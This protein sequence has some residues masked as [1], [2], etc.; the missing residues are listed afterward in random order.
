[1]KRLISAFFALSVLVGCDDTGTGQGASATQGNQYFLNYRYVDAS[2]ADGN[3]AFDSLLAGQEEQAR[4]LFVRSTT[5][6]A[7]GA[8]RH[9]IAAR[10]QADNIATLGAVVGAGIGIAAIRSADVTTVRGQQ[11]LQSQLDTLGQIT[12][13]IGNGAQDYAASRI[14]AQARDVQLNQ[15]RSVVISDHR[16]ARSIVRVRNNTTG[17]YCTGFFIRPHVIATASHCFD[18]GHSMS[19]ER[20]QPERGGDF[21]RGRTVQVPIYQNLVNLKFENCP[22]ARD[23]NDR[24]R[25]CGAEDFAMFV[26]PQRS[27]YFIPIGSP[28]VVGESLTTIGYSA[29][30]NA[31]YFLRLDVGCSVQAVSRGNLAR[32]NCT[33]YPGDSG[34][35]LVRI[36]P[37]RGIGIEAV[38][39]ASSGRTGGSLDRTTG[40]R[41]YAPA[42][43]LNVFFENPDLDPRARL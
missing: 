15:W 2:R 35:P 8:A 26:T 42:A 9:R 34:G 17:G 37:G 11:V 30:L 22:G 28:A 24:V 33:G 14:T 19:A 12:D 41:S 6:L 36:T 23:D 38:G 1:M 16:I 13:M 5:T 18:L 29:D 31:G 32:T 4:A 25:L 20:Q 7:D 10:Q 43:G 27:Q 39:I 3:A 40:R 21:M